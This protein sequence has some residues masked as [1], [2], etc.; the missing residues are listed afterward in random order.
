[1]FNLCFGEFNF[2][3]WIVHMF[4]LFEKFTIKTCMFFWVQEVFR[5]R[6][7]VVAQILL[8]IWASYWPGTSSSLRLHWSLNF[9]HLVFL[10]PLLTVQSCWII[11]L[12]N[13]RQFYNAVYFGNNKPQLKIKQKQRSNQTSRFVMRGLMLTFSEFQSLLLLFWHASPKSY[14]KRCCKLECSWKLEGS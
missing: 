11:S 14:Q 3:Q 13:T 4:K 9:C 5:Y 6:L 2:I 1:M 12:Q 7:W 8:T 10:R